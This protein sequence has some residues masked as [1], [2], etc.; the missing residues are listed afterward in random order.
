MTGS[1][2]VE[3]ATRNL[4]PRG[5]AGV[6]A[7]TY[8]LLGLVWIIP[9]DIAV[10]HLPTDQQALE[11]LQ[12]AKGLIYVALSGL[13][14][15]AVVYWFTRVLGSNRAELEHQR[16]HLSRLNR[17]HATLNSVSEALLHGANDQ[18]LLDSTARAIVEEGGF[19]WAWIGLFEPES[20]ML[21]PR[22]AASAHGLARSV[23]DPFVLT[24]ADRSLVARAVF[25]GRMGH[26]P[27][28][29]DPTLDRLAPPGLKYE[30]VAAFPLRGATEN[31]GVI[32]IHSTEPELFAD[33]DE[34]RLLTRVA[35]T[36]SLGLAYSDERRLLH[37]LNQHDP[38]TGVGTRGFIESRLAAALNNAA[39][40]DS[41]VA[42]MVLDI[43]EFRQIND[44]GGREAGDHV[45]VAVVRCL[46]GVVRPGDSIG[47]LGNDEFAL[48][49]QDLGSV[50]QASRL[51]NRVSDRFPHH[52]EFD[53]QDLRITVSIG[54]AIYP[55]DAHDPAELLSRAEVALHSQ[56]EGQTSVI[57]YYAPEY[58]RRA[59]EQRALETALRNADFDREFR[60][61]WQP[62]IDPRDHALCGAEVLLRWHN[63][64]LGDI[65][66]AR[67]IPLAERTGQI[68]ALGHWVLERACDQARAWADRGL[69][70]DVA[71]N[72]ALEQLQD[73]DFVPR[74]E[75][76]LPTGDPGWTLIFELTESQFMAEPEPVIETCRRL[77]E[78]GCR[79]H[80]DDFGTGYSALHYLVHLPLDGLKI[81]RSF[82]QRIETDSGVRAITRA[83]VTLATQLGLDV[84]AEGV[85]TEGQLRAVCDIGDCMIQG[86]HLGR[87]MPADAFENWAV[88]ALSHQG[89]H[90][91]A[92]S[93]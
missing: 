4:G 8:V 47:R 75:R 13:L 39:Q 5:V 73:P 36:L 23:A 59:S 51:V 17:A 57:T 86:Y 30:A 67:F 35:D 46:A 83:V 62:I 45:L 44:I 70:V 55:D 10:V 2:I 7:V 49:C 87:P 82:I 69:P 78:L 63:D 25:R 34:V 84:I 15:Y 16:E 9:S 64:K 20:R 93:E 68:R 48:V 90:A 24:S 54:V 19:P 27:R 14:L 80:L 3:R 72:I 74:V 40:R 11:R 28:G 38:V 26:V 37:Q 12:T 33:Q 71:V 58:D 1:G 81:D 76:L 31:L 50:E 91:R 89:N 42:V 88:S 22:A 66:P 21:T 53:G 52:V 65:P 77:R 56:P 61:A 6:A 29:E 41:A 60:L 43:D 18:F 32:A 79:I 85:E 92:P